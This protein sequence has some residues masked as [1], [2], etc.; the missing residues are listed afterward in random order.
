M[1]N[2]RD[3]MNIDVQYLAIAKSILENGTEK[4]DRTLTGTKSIFS[5]QV[6]HN[7]SEGFP[8]LTTKKVFWKGIV[9]ELLWFLRGE[10]NIK[11]LVENNNN[12]WVGDAFKSYLFNSEWLPIANTNRGFIGTKANSDEIMTQEEFINKIKTDDEFAK[13]WGEL[14]PIYGKQWRKV[15]KVKKNAV[16]WEHGSPTHYEELYDIDQIQQAIDTLKTNPDSRRIIVNAWNVD[17]LKDMVLPPCHWAFEL[18]TE[19]LTIEERISLLD[20]NNPEYLTDIHFTASTIT[21]DLL[22]IAK[23]PKRRLSLKWHQRSVDTFLGLPFNIASYAL[24]LEILS[25][26]VNMVSGTLVGDLTNVHIYNNHIE[27]MEEQISRD[28]HK[29]KYPKLVIGNNTTW[30]NGID[31]MLGSVIISDFQVE[32]YESY[33]PIKGELSN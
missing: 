5:A 20:K 23:I 25:K 6:V 29:H 28:P 22:D 24:L 7:M 21:H 11:W 1:I 31:E 30:G 15:G 26:E 13:K 10:T 14:G 16:A 2:K 9:S 33:P 17:S 32:G 3:N 8:L 27:Q 18:Y 12:I 19:E 4:N